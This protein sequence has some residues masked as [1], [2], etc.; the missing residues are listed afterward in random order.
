MTRSD[1][2]T[3][4]S[5]PAVGADEQHESVR[6]RYRRFAGHYDRSYG[7]YTAHSRRL[8]L[9]VLADLPEPRSILDACCGTGGVTAALA[10][11]HPNSEIVGVDLSAE[12]LEQARQRLNGAVH[13]VRF[14]EAPAESL[15]LATASVDL[16]VCANALHLVPEPREAIRE[17]S[18]VL[19]PGGTAIVLDWT[20][21]SLPMRLLAW[22]LNSTQRTRRR[23]LD[24]RALDRT[25]VQAGLVVERIDSIRIPP[26][27]GLMLA[28]VTKPS[29]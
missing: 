12:M 24:R 8:V 14:V 11:R 6:R 3:L 4:P 18:R 26:A 15:P 25:F 1:R 13:R 20:L 10:S 16:V 17:F 19:A 5:A 29:T 9:E 2:I 28:R 22:W 21:D 27:W 7:R 23:L